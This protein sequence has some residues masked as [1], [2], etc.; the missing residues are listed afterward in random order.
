VIRS[1][2]ITLL[3]LASAYAHGQTMSAA[4]TVNNYSIAQKRLLVIS[5]AQFTNLISQNNFDKDSIMIMACR[6]TGLPFL[7]PYN[8]GFA[9]KVSGGADFI[10]T[11]KIAQAVLLLN[12]QAGEKKIQLLVELG[13]WYLHQAGIYKKDLD[14]A[15]IYIDA[16]TKLSVAGKYDNWQSECRLLL[17]QLNNQ[18]GDVS[19]CRKILSQII[20][21]GQHQLNLGPVARAYQCL[22]DLLLLNDTIKPN[23]YDE[24]LKIYRRLNSKEKQIELLGNLVI[25]H[26]DDR[27]ALAENETRQVL[28]L[29]Q[30]TGF[31][32]SLFA[33]NILSYILIN[34]GKFLEGFEYSKAAIDNLKWSGIAGIAAPF[35]YRAGAAYGSLGKKEDDLSWLKK[36]LETRKVENHLFWYKGLFQAHSL[37]IMMG[38]P[39]ES[40]AMLDTITI[41]FPP[42]TLWE[43]IQIVSCIGECYENLHRSQ[44]ADNYYTKLIELANNNPLVDPYGELT[45]T[46]L[47]I[48][49]YYVS[50]HD[51][52]KARLFLEQAN[53]K[54]KND[55]ETSALKYSLLFEIDSSEGYYKSALQNHIKYK[56]YYD[57][58]TSIDQRKKMDELTIKYAAEKKDQ[59]IKLLKQQGIVQQTELKQNKL[60]RNIMVAGTLLLLIIVGLLFSQFKL[61]QR[62]NAAMNKKN[63][64][65]QH[66]V[67]EKEWLL[68]EVHHRVKNNL[69]TVI[70]L[71]ESQA[72]YLENDALKA[73]ENSQHRIYAMSL[74]H[75]KLY[76]T[77]D[78]K[79]IDMSVYL[80]EF[81]RYLDESFDTHYRIKFQLNIEVINLGVSQAI[82]IA[83]I[84]NESVTNSIKYAFPQNRKG[85]IEITMHK[86]AD[87]IA[88]IIAD[89]GI[90]IDE[91]LLNAPSKSL[92]LKLMKG[93]SGD[94]NALIDIKNE[95]GTK[96]KI[97]FNVDPLDQSNK[98]LTAIKQTEIF[99]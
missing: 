22:G 97:V 19:G 96:I 21:S 70:S 80:P 88:L 6:L 55:P 94:I 38:R 42:V 8:E 60:T 61:K 67:S 26:V 81:I 5:T 18:R 27:M 43:K 89:N 36:G 51:L 58:W 16:A 37:L 90:G 63:L 3:L 25:C 12:K 4:E 31:S 73:I 78:V 47:L 7:L 87:Q 86:N 93:L 14:S 56:L 72:A 49:K 79:T 32:H 59:D 24:S 15:A 10:N 39:G 91:S 33:Q 30:S 23:Y 64:A 82:P 77:E 92:G 74:I 2:A 69:H 68:K 44:L 29:Q 84:I 54:E 48:A 17:A 13:I 34:Q 75:Q 62:T 40:L 98:S 52:P 85:I 35:F 66:L 28:L 50:Q 11:G 76:Q 71:L 57:S 20:S 46:Y 53:K 1:A 83:L 45:G 9:D 41:K 99:A 65:L 95:N